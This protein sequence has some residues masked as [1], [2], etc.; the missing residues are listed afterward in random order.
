VPLRTPLRFAS[1]LTTSAGC[2]H[3]VNGAARTAKPVSGG[4]AGDYR[5]SPE[6]KDGKPAIRIEV[7][8]KTVDRLVNEVV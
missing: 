7:F 3:R 4:S 8:G 6:T 1:W 2:G 5:I